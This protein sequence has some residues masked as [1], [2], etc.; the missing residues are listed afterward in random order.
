LAFFRHFFITICVFQFLDLFFLQLEYQG[1]RITGIEVVT[2]KTERNTLRTFWQKN[3]VDLSRGM[4]FAPRGG[5]FAR[6]THLQ[7]E[8][9]QY[10]I[11]VS[12]FT[13]YFI[14]EQYKTVKNAIGGK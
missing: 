5:V 1:I 12:F 11:N 14:V 4:D 8:P 6:F 3:D 7:H 9:F 10:R 13:L 2:P